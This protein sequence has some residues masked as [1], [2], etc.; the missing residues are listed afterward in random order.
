MTCGNE[1]RNEFWK[2]MDAPGQG[3]T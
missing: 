1:W 3:E 2:G